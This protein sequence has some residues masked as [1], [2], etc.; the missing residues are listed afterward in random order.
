MLDATHLE[1]ATITTKTTTTTGISYLLIN[2]ER[3]DI[4]HRR[5]PRKL[6]KNHGGNS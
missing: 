2:D 1:I 6:G 3:A 4:E 5:D